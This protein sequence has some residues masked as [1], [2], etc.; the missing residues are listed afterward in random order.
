MGAQAQFSQVPGEVEYKRKYTLWVLIV[1][2]LVCW[3]AAII[4]Y[5]T[6]EK[7]LVQEFSTHYTLGGGQP[8]GSVGQSPSPPPQG[9]RFCPSCGAQG[10]KAGGFCSSC[11]KPVPS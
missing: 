1:L 4:Y 5:F 11:G 7:V 10:Q 6:R 8:S 2:I 3:P 9:G